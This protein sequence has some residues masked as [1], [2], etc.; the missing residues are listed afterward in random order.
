MSIAVFGSINMDVTAYMHR[1]PK[2]GEGPSE[3]AREKGFL[4]V[5]VFG[6]SESG[7][8]KTVLIEGKGDPGYKLTSLLLGESALCLARDEAK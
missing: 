6:E 7:Q 5:R 2:P 4:R 8:K 1:L 3:E